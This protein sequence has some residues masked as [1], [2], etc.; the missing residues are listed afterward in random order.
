MDP[1]DTHVRYPKIYICLSTG[2]PTHTIGPA[3]S[4]SSGMGNV[5]LSIFSFFTVLQTVQI[6]D[7]DVD[8][9]PDSFVRACVE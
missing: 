9:F 8:D 4:A 7:D 2:T 1:I 6:D 3:A 5:V